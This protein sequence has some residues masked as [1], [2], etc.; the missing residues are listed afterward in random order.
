MPGLKPTNTTPR[1]YLGYILHCR[2]DALKDEEPTGGAELRLAPEYPDAKV[3]R[4]RGYNNK[5][6]DEPT[7]QAEC[8][9][10]Q[11][12]AARGR[13]RTGRTRASGRTRSS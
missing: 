7:R 6:T 13:G 1:Q 2:A 8:R 9:A 10:A 3:V 4:A 5:V 12:C 11:V